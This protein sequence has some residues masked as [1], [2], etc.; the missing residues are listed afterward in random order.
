[1]LVDYKSDRVTGNKFEWAERH[2]VQLEIYKKAVT[3]ATAMEVKEALLYSF[4]L[5][6]AVEI[7]FGN[8]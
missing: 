6:E 2:R 1:V 5:G 8:N 3:E 4:D 7:S